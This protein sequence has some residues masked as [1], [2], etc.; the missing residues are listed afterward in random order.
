MTRRGTC[1]SF[2]IS[3]EGGRGPLPRRP[4]PIPTTSLTPP[5]SSPSSAHSMLPSPSST[6]HREP[7]RH[8]LAIHT[9]SDLLV[10]PPLHLNG[11]FKLYPLTFPSPSH[12]TSTLSYRP[13]RLPIPQKLYHIM[14]ALEGRSETKLDAILEDDSVNIEAEST[15]GTPSGVRRLPQRQASMPCLLRSASLLCYCPSLGDD[16]ST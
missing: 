9:V 15:Q 12:P 7:G 8:K 14:R 10:L 6:L 16:E 13:S 11:P 1:I 3:R 5:L 4:G 2:H